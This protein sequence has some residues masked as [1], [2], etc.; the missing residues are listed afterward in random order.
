MVRDFILRS[1]RVYME[2]ANVCVRQSN[3]NF[4]YPVVI[5]QS[6]DTTSSYHWHYII[7]LHTVFVLIKQVSTTIWIQ[8]R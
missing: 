4:E 3:K 7:S 8:H 5:R 2:S 6:K 1:K